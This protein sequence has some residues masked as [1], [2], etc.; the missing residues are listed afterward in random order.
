MRNKDTILLENAYKAILENDNG[1]KPLPMESLQRV[2][3]SIC[4][5]IGGIDHVVECL[6]VAGEFY[7]RL[8]HKGAGT[9]SYQER[10]AEYYNL[11]LTLNGDATNLQRFDAE[12][13]KNQKELS[14]RREEE[15]E[16]PNFGL[17]QD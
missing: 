7:S 16:L 11:E 15:G 5:G 13:Q 1:L 14:K 4:E 10:K 6:R 9:P 2:Y 8:Q 17:S 3:N 12:Y